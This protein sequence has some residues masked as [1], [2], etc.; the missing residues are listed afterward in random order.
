LR[1]LDGCHS[2][3]CCGVHETAVRTGRIVG[4]DMLR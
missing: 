1:Q 3:E 2:V 4:D